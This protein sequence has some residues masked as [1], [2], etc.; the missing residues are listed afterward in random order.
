MIRH[1]LQIVGDLVPMDLLRVIKI[2]A[3]TTCVLKYCKRAKEQY[4]SDIFKIIV[5]KL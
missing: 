1:G 5:L 4:K 2:H 3:K